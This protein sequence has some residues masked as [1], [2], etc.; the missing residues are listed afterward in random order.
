LDITFR[1]EALMAEF[2]APLEDQLKRVGVEFDLEAEGSG[3]HDN[4]CTGDVSDHRP[5]GGAP[6]QR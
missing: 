3:R 1:L 2:V 6:S 5:Q 4:G